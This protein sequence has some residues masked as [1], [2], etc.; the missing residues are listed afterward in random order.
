MFT[1][2]TLTLAALATSIISM[3]L[4]MIAL[5]PQWKDQLAV[6]RDFVLWTA[7]AVFVIGFLGVNWR[8]S[9]VKYNSQETATPS[10]DYASF[11]RSPEYSHSPVSRPSLSPIPN[12]NRGQEFLAPIQR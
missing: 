6:L 2:Q 1:Q 11:D 7:L 3:L 9:V 5:W 12:F 10:S 8:R 4:S